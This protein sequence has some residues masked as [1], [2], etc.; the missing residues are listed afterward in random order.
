MNRETY[1][2]V[3]T[4]MV[5]FQSNVLNFDYH[6][7]CKKVSLFESCLHPL[8][9]VLH[10]PISPVCEQTTWSLFDLSVNKLNY[11]FKAV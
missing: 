2:F 10:T 1:Y 4:D 11:N 8:K 7:I 6:L 3:Q 5:S 9:V